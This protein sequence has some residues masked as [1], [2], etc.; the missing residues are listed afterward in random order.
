M[1]E[2]P[3]SPDDDEPAAW[4]IMVGS[5]H[6]GWSGYVPTGRLPFVAIQYTPE[7]QIEFRDA[8]HAASMAVLR[9]ITV[10]AEGGNTKTGRDVLRSRLPGW[11]YDEAVESDEEDIGGQ[12]LE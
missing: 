12:R 11:S 7:Q 9:S 8:M 6:D 3:E 4:A 1:T 2:P 5:E 10:D